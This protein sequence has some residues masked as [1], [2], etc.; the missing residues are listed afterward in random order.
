MAR[1]AASTGKVSRISRLVTRMFQ[2]KIGIRNITIP[3][4]RRVKMVAIRLTPPR[5]PL[6]PDR[7]SPRIHRLA[8]MAGE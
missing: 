2:V 3:G 5:I 7:S 6:V 8:P 1:A 4:A